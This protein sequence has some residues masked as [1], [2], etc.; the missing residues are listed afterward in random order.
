[1]TVPNLK[2][3]ELMLT[4]PGCV[5]IGAGLAA[6]NTAESLRADGYAGSVTIVG[7]EELTPYERPGLSK[8]Y[9]QGKADRDSL[10]AHDADWYAAHDVTVR[11]GDGVEEIDRDQ[12]TIRLVS[13]TEI[14]YRDLVITSGS[15]PRTLNLP[16]VDLSGVHTLR[17]LGDSTDLRGALADRGRWVLIGAGWIGLEV[18]AAARL[19]GCDVTVVES[20]ALPL[21]GPLGSTLAEHFAALH[22]SHG[23]DLRTGVR[24]TGIVGED[25]AVTGVRVG[26]AVIP[27]DV[28]LVAVGASPN[29]RLA[30]QAGLAVDRGVLVDEHL[31]TNDPAI[32]AAGDV[33]NAFNTSLGQHVRVEH[34]DNA[35]RQGKL[36]AATILGTDKVYDWQP[37]FFTDQYDLGMEYVGQSGP[38][39]EVIIRGDLD[40]G[41]FIA[42][43]RRHDQITA[44]MNVNIWDVNDQLR[45]LIGTSI[46][47]DRLRDTA[48]EL[49]DLPSSVG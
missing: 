47:A 17:T 15:S 29:T 28:V 16:G 36:A 37:Y 42:F 24:V 35:I 12:Q 20:A 18:A 48:V 49:A 11:T 33:A 38:D 32:L 10:L 9:L 23:V 30:E 13:G 25:G 31:R 4:T 41:E 27:A 2:G 22:R 8:D 43:W 45:D 34:W 5:L 26:D 3:S 19:A 7:D 40:G 6:A 21:Q 39:D 44:A 14:P 1:M 46:P